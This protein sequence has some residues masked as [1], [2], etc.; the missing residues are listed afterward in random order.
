MALASNILAALLTVAC[1]DKGGNA[2]ITRTTCCTSRFRRCRGHQRAAHK[3]PRGQVG[4]GRMVC[5]GSARSAQASQASVKADLVD[6]ASDEGPI[7]SRGSLACRRSRHA[8]RKQAR[9]YISRVKS[10]RGGSCIWLR[11]IIMAIGGGTHTTFCP[12]LSKRR[13][14]AR[15]F[16]GSR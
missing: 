16:H 5:L 7:F 15:A 12:Q 2:V 9:L 14:V 8:W 13:C 1:L 3:W 4:S 11:H 10:S 6:T